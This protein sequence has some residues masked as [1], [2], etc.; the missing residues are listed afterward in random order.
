MRKSRITWEGAF[1]HVMSRG[2]EG[3]PLFREN[4]LKEAFLNIL[5][6]KARQLKIRILAFCILDNHYHLVVE[7]STGRLSDLM[8]R[9]NSQFAIAYRKGHP[10][11]GSIFQDR[12]KSTLIENDAYLITSI[13]YTLYNPV[14]AGIVRHYSRYPWTSVIELLS[15]KEDGLIDRDFVLDL[16]TDREEFIRQMD[17]FQ[18]SK[19]LGVKRCEFGEIL[20]SDGFVA[21]VEK[22]CERRSLPDPV[23]RKRKDD[24]YFEPL[25]KVIQEFEITKGRNIDFLDLTTWRDK[26][27]RGELL[28]DIREHCGLKYSEIAELSLFS[29]IQLGT[30]GSLYWHSKKRLKDEI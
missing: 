8:K 26:K 14:R 9:V 17:A 16:F 29:D 30:L 18:Y 15:R 22:R 12:F 10:G 21:K 7:N 4:C 19:K 24:R 5:A 3:R 1:H 25:A 23:K 6:E 13:M 11:R 2:H 27:L 20:G 28:V